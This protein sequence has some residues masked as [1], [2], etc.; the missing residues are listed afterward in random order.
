M[1]GIKLLTALDI[2]NGIKGM[3]TT[4]Q[5]THTPCSLTCTNY[6]IAITVFATCH[7]HAFT[8]DLLSRPELWAGRTHT[9]CRWWPVH[10]FRALDKLSDLGLVASVSWYSKLWSCLNMYKQNGLLVTMRKPVYNVKDGFGRSRKLVTSSLMMGTCSERHL[11]LVDRVAVWTLS[12]H[13]IRTHILKLVLSSLGFLVQS[14]TTNIKCT[15]QLAWNMACCFILHGIC[16][17]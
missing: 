16:C 2:P 14:D 12:V 11:L 9:R 8:V 5:H 10:P 7:G 6:P 17:K 3:I 1:V 4:P 15:R 13:W